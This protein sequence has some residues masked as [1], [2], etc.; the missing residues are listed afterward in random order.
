M[1][2][3]AAALPFVDA[4][5]FQDFKDPIKQMAEWRKA[6]GKPVLLTDAAR[7]AKGESNYTRNDGK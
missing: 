2:M 6:T 3:I 4:L 1:P 7:T 5:S